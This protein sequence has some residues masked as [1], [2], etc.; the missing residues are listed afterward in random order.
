LFVA[1]SVMLLLGGAV[2]AVKKPDPFPGKFGF[3]EIYHALVLAGA[4]PLF[5]LVAITL[6]A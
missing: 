6:V 2:Y 3:H 1:G 4:V 5:F